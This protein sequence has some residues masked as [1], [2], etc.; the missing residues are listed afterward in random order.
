MCVCVCVHMGGWVAGI[1]ERRGKEFMERSNAIRWRRQDG[2][3][4]QGCESFSRA[5]TRSLHARGGRDD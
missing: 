4:I 5:G 3:D 2:E 1:R